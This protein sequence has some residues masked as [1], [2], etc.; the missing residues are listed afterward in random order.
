MAIRN[1]DITDSKKDQEKLQPDEV[2]MDLPDVQ[3]IPGQENVRPAHLRAIGDVTASSDDE[4]GKGL[5]DDDDEPVE[6]SDVSDIEK[7]L[8]QQ[9]SESTGSN[10][11]IDVRNAKVDATDDDGDPLEEDDLDIPGSEDDD[12]NEEIGEE[13]EENNEYSLGDNQ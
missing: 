13:D 11:D 3:D 9:T 5:L 6:E 2:I 7:E 4:E 12:D 1:T 10:E 8:L